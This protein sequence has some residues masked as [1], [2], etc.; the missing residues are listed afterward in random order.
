MNEF[1]GE[2]D[3]KSGFPVPFL[4]K[5][6]AQRCIPEPAQTANLEVFAM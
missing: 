5:I 6:P 3:E 2:E 4:R 1:M